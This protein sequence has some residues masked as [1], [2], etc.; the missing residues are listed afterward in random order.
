MTAGTFEP[1]QKAV[2]FFFF[3]FFSSFCPYFFPLSQSEAE[4]AAEVR[5]KR[6][7]KRPT[8][9]SEEEREDDRIRTRVTE[10]TERAEEEGCLPDAADASSLDEESG[11]WVDGEDDG[12][13][14]IDDGA[15]EM[16][17]EYAEFQREAVGHGVA[18]MS[19]DEN[20]QDESADEAP[21]WRGDQEEEGYEGEMT[22]EN[23]AYDSFLQLRTEYPFL[24]F[25]VVRDNGSGDRTKYPLTMTLV[26][27]TWADKPENNQVV[28]LHVSNICRTK[29]DVESDDDS[30][31]SYIGDDGGSEG[32]G[33]DDAEEVNA[34][35]PILTHRVI[36]HHG[37][38]NR[39]RFSPHA[40][41]EGGAQFV[42]TW[43][44]EG[45]VQIFDIDSDIRMLADH[46]N[47]SKEQAKAWSNPKK[48][49][50]LKFCTPSSSHKTEGYGLDWNPVLANVL[51][52]GDCD[53]ALY[54]WQPTDDGRWKSIASST[55]ESGGGK[56]VEE[57]QWS[58]TQSQVLTTAR[59]GGVVQVWDTR[60]MRKCKIAWQADS[61][62]INV[63]SWNRAREASHLLVTGADSGAV[64]VWDL[65]KLPSQEP[66]QQLRW[67]KKS[68]TSVEFSLHN[69]SALAVTG[70]DGQCT[71]WD[72]SLERD[73]S[74]EQQVI[75]ELFGRKDLVD[76]PDQLLFQHQ[77]LSHPKEVHWHTQIPG[78]VVTTDY[79]GLHL[80]RPM[81]WLSL[82]R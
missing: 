45:H 17:D 12:E 9:E 8:R 74:E 32:E 43:S 51:A 36:K 58:P 81:N 62:D 7:T 1:K 70:D 57:I 22:Y 39:V 66:I 64:A 30:E 37:S 16:D 67:H 53:G 35:E 33:D 82:V 65:R 50:P 27:G 19:L 44:D 79:N 72:L 34:G 38:V 18:A 69:Q 75:G 10:E 61:T 11:E 55:G 2:L 23:R 56:S 14:I 77:G 15:E 28:I 80:F 3:H 4:K 68:I 78:M 60:D 26:C 54:I 48:S 47:W 6:G 21:V 52:S 40:N 42:A 59:A 49:Q 41:P 24:S 5:M 31:A 63:A 29:H 73:P 71:L 25:D 20:A 46:A 13:E 76:L